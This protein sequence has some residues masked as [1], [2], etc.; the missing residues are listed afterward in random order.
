MLA[1]IRRYHRWLMLF[2]GL[3]FFVWSFSGVYMVVVDIHSI[4]GE[5]L[6]ADTAP[7]LHHSRAAHEGVTFNLDR[8]FA[9]YP[10]AQNVR[11]GW[12]DTIL[13]Y[14]FTAPEPMLIDAGA[15]QPISINKQLAADIALGALAK[16][17]RI[18][19]VE[20]IMKDAPSEIGGRALPIWR[21][22]F[23]GINSPTL[24]V[25]DKT[26]EIATVRKNTWRIFDL[27]WRLHIMDYYDGEDTNNIL[28]NLFSISGLLAVIS[29]LL[30]L[31]FRLFP[32][33]AQAAKT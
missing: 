8:L 3:Q 16:P 25:N 6:L 7:S 4:H 29:G 26:G 15:G 21:I 10:Q 20:L 12:L 13:V 22:D 27:L 5:D 32:N 28:L 31:W 30:L 23:E 11:L 19:N 1:V 14:R 9:K 24:Y 18:S 33:S 17:L 2:L